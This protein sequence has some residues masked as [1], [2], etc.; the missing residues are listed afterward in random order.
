MEEEEEQRWQLR[1]VVVDA[2]GVMS[3]AKDVAE[4]IDAALPSTSAADD[5]ITRAGDCSICLQALEA[6]EAVRLLP[7]CSHAF[8]SAC[9]D[10]WL[11]IRRRCWPA[12]CPNCRRSILIP[13]RVKVF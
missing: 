6:G 10:N 13:P 4:Q 12:S 11:A 3:A 8:H 1:E 2:D 7:A 5:A 9:I